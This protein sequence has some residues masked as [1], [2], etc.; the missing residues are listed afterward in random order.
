MTGFDGDHMISGMK[1]FFAVWFVLLASGGLWASEF[2]QFQ[3]SRVL[4]EPSASTVEVEDSKSGQSFY[5][6][7]TLVVAMSDIRSAELQ[8]RELSDG[9]KYQVVVIGLTE[10]GVSKLKKMTTDWANKRIGIVVLNEL[11]S[12]SVIRES[13]V[14]SSTLDIVGIPEKK[15]HELIKAVN[16]HKQ[17]ASAAGK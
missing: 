8:E 7:Q 17:N 16:E 12:V 9:R 6:D 3:I 11:A 2:V 13:M 15:A 5:L 1:K 4:D 10:E 14:I